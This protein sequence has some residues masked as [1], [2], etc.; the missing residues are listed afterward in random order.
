MAFLELNDIHQ[1]FEGIK[2]LKGLALSIEKGE[3]CLLYGPSGSGKTTLLNLMARLLEPDHGTLKLEGKAYS[4]Y[5]HAAAFRLQNIGFIFQEFHLLEALTVSQNIEIIQAV[6]NKKEAVPSLSELVQPLA[7]EPFV[8]TKVKH[9]S[10]GERQRVALARAFANR[11]TLLLADEPTASLDPQN[12]NTTI[13]HLFALC[14]QTNAT[15][16]VVSHDEALL[17]HTSFSHVL[18]LDGGTLQKDAS[19]S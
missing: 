11:P 7:L 17:S 1:S 2:V 14:E 4:D 6:S 13:G 10:R 9:L 16:I 15:C 5:G 19:S 3:H 18:R 12:R 8:K